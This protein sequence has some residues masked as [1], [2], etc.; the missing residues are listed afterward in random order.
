MTAPALTLAP[1]ELQA[2]TGRRRVDAQ[3]R[4][5]DAMR[6]PYLVR[7]DHSLA[8]SRS[9]VEAALGGAP[10]PGTMRSAEPE[11]QP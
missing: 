2:L 10:A 5:L 3:R 11:L 8:V 4:E 9:A 7:T 6:I 1:D